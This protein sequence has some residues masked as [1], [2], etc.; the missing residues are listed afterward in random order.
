[1]AESEFDG[2]D[3]PALVSAFLLTL[4]LNKRIF[5]SGDFAK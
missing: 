2:G 4:L 1:M 3:R 5:S